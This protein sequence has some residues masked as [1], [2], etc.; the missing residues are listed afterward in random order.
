MV[1]RRLPTFGNLVVIE[2]ETSVAL[3]LR[4]NHDGEAVFT[5]REIDALIAHLGTIRPP[6]PKAAD[7][8]ED[9]LG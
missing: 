8:F 7:P 6:A 1:D 5:Y 4:T 3:S 9:L 2:R